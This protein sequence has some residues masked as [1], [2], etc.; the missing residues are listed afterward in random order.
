MQRKNMCGYLPLKRYRHDLL[1]TTLSGLSSSLC[2]V[3]SFLRSTLGSVGQTLSWKHTEMFPLKK[4]GFFPPLCPPSAA[5][6]NLTPML[7]LEKV[8][9][10]NI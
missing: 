9:K 2:S 5:I 1:A 8:F 3:V 6:Y 10:R 4:T 7:F